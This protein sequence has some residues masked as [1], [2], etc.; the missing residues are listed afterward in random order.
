MEPVGFAVGIMGLVGL[1]NTCLGLLDKFDSW[2]DCGSDLRSLAA[3]FHAH[4]LPL[5]NWGHAVGFEQ[6]ILSDQH[7][8]RLDAP[9]TLSTVQA[10]LLSIRD[11][12]KSSDVY[13]TPGPPASATALER[14]NR[15]ILFGRKPRAHPQGLLESRRQKLSWA[16]RGK[17]KLIARV[18]Q[19]SKL[20]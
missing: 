13:L 14:P 9:R 1:F 6:G 18:E 8:H 2:R 20:V 12:C 3:Q 19:F 16:P 11:A 10:L 15:N 5:K 17:T 7:S 4:K